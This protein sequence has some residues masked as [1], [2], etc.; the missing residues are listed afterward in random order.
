MQPPKP[1]LGPAIKLMGSKWRKAKKYPP[2]QYST[3]IEPFAGGAGYSLLWWDRQVVLV[4]KDPII[5]GIWDYLIRAKPNEI[6][7]IPVFT[8][9]GQTVD[10]VAGNWPQEVQ[11]LLGFWCNFGIEKPRR[12][13][14]WRLLG[15]VQNQYAGFWNEKRRAKTAELAKRI[16]HWRIIHG[17]YTEAPNTPATW[18]IDPPY[19]E[20]RLR[21][22]RFNLADTD[23]PALAHWC[24]NRQGQVIV[25]ELA[26]ANWLPF[27][28]LYENKGA[29]LVQSKGKKTLRRSHEAVWMNYEDNTPEDPL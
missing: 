7:R 29:N 25:C 4:E 22:Y 1:R 19:S 17:D 3:I 24:R 18:F 23:Y 20:K 9:I 11:W 13:L 5:A 10:E 27:Q 14:S 26:N 16:K 8:H 15:D 6:L 2:P 28:P 21:R 12:T